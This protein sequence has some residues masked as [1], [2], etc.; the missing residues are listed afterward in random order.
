MRNAF[1]QTPSNGRIEG[2][3]RRIKQI[4]WLRQFIEL[5]FRNTS[6][7]IQSQTYKR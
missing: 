3:N 4:V 1:L 2:I 7:T 6:T 5:F